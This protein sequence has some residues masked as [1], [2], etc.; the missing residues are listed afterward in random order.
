MNG[1]MRLDVGAN[2]GHADQYIP[3][4]GWNGARQAGR[5]GVHQADGKRGFVAAA[6]AAK[7][8]G[9]EQSEIEGGVLL[10]FRCS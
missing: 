2:V 6:P 7:P 3:C 1:V 5:R 8:S 9:I 4:A 10:L